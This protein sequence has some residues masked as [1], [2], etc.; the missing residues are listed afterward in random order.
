MVPKLHAKGRSFRG[1]AAYLLH[2]KG[3]A[4]TDARV[5]WSET[6]NLATDNPHIAWRIMA[7]TAMDQQRLKVRA[8]VKNTGRK[9]AD[10]VLHLTLSWHPEEKSKLSRDEMVRA[11]LGALQALGAEDRQA[12]FVCHDDEPQPHL[13]VLLNRVSP[14]DGRMLPSSKEKLALSRWAE[15]YEKNRGQILCEERVVNNAARRRGEFVRGT[16]D[17]PRHIFELEAAHG[18]KSGIDK[19]QEQQRG[20]DRAVAK[21]RRERAERRKREWTDL[22]SRQKEAIRDIRRRYRSEAARA[23]ESVRTAFEPRWT[24]L[25]REH[26]KQLRAF[27]SKENRL[28]GRLRNAFSAIDF[29]SIVRPRARALARAFDAVSSKADRLASLHRAHAKSRR[30]LRGQQREEERRA[31]GHI[32]ETRDREIAECRAAYIAERSSLILSHRMEAAAHDRAWKNRSEER[33]AAYERHR[34]SPQD[35]QADEL[36]RRLRRARDNRDE[37]G[38]RPHRGW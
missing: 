6:R 17:T 21:A 7:A 1:A 4:K 10:A 19:V 26:E 9:S 32:R 18:Q 27:A 36:L 5:A 29:R 8:G 13:H 11:G 30:E 3:R 15:A 12:L 16:T 28:L 35:L 22:N 25:L 34:A 33:R 14:E 37:R 20:N 24:A 23:R 38:H 2:D 31:V